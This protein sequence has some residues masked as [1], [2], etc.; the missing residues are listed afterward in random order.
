LG[1]ETATSR[2]GLTTYQLFLKVVITSQWKISQVHELYYRQ[3]G[4]V[5]FE[6]GTCL[7]QFAHNGR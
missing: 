4:L 5:R 3:S 2:V 6:A 1:E 7:L